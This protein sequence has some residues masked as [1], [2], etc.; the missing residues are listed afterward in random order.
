M[1]HQETTTQ[2]NTPEARLNPCQCYIR[3]SDYS[4]YYCP[5]HAAAPETAA[6]RDRLR[7]V[8]N[9]AMK[10]ID[11]LS[12]RKSQIGLLEAAKYAYD[13]LNNSKP[14]GKSNIAMMKLERAITL[15]AEAQK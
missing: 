2:G 6:E 10:V 12:D 1:T 13:V 3:Q 5:L 14:F 7:I 15:D 9:E 4:I 8:C 11:I